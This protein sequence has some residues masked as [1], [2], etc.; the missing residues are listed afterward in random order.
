[1]LARGTLRG[2]AASKAQWHEAALS[3]A[4]SLVAGHTY[5]LAVLAP[6]GGG[7]LALR[8]TSSGGPSVASAQSWLTA[9]PASWSVGTAYMNGPA[10]AYVLGK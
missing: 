1:L 10:A 4:L 2:H 7:T 6:A 8:D 5:W 3:P 9:L